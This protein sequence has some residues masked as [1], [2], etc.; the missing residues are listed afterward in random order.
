MLNQIYNIIWRITK[1]TVKKIVEVLVFFTRMTVYYLVKALYK[2]FNLREIDILKFRNVF[3]DQDENLKF[4]HSFSV[5]RSED[6]IMAW[7]YIK[8]IIYD[9]D[10]DD[11]VKTELFDFMELLVCE[12]ERGLF[13]TIYYYILD[14]GVEK[15]TW[16]DMCLQ[17]IFSNNK[18]ITPR[19]EF[20]NPM[21]QRKG[22]ELYYNRQREKNN[23]V[24]DAK[25]R[26]II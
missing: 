7:Y 24:D 15:A 12:A 2:I 25:A 16:Q 10:V 9:L 8:D 3:E 11:D 4:K 18:D 17:E 5:H 22:L 1:W 21:R 23:Q 19:E 6:F 26:G 13:D 20:S 14:R